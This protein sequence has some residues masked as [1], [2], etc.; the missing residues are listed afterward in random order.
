MCGTFKNLL[1]LNRS[2]MEQALATK[3]S[4]SGFTCLG[5]LIK[6]QLFE[7]CRTSL[8]YAQAGRMVL[9]NELITFFYRKQQPPQPKAWQGPNPIT[10]RASTSTPNGT[11]KPLP[12]TPVQ[13]RDKS[14]ADSNADKH[15]H[16]RALY[17]I[18]NFIV[19]LQTYHMLWT[20]YRPQAV[21]RPHTSS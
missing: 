5:H 7:S 2:Q 3:L 1:H 21:V 4:T 17:I 14:L 19:R 15:A 18:A 8:S 16:D 9:I 10:Q 20:R 6:P 11:E 12:K 13:S